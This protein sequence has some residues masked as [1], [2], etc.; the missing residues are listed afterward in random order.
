MNRPPTPL[1]TTR[2]PLRWLLG[3]VLG[4][5]VIGDAALAWLSWNDWNRSRAWV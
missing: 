4:L 2:T 1:P 5:L 3:V